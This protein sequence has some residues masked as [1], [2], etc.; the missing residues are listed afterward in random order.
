MSRGQR[1][2]VAISEEDVGGW[3][4]GWF[5]VGVFRKP[6]ILKLR[7]PI[8]LHHFLKKVKIAYICNLSILLYIVLH[9]FN[10]ILITALGGSY[11]Y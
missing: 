2:L 7:E 1:A 10:I 6:S 9:I 5:V 8:Y 11:Y 3:H 4:R